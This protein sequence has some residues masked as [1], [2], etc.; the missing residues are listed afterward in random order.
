LNEEQQQAL[1]MPLASRRLRTHVARY[2]SNL[3]SPAVISIPLVI[4]VALYHTHN[5]FTALAYAAATLFFLSAGPMLYIAVGVRLGKFTDI[6]V[7][8]RSQR[9]G[10]FLFS[11]LS[12]LVGLFMLTILH[13]P[14][15]LQTVMLTV[16]LT[17]CAYMLITFWWK[18][19][20]HASILAGAVTML[21]ALYGNMML[22]GYVLVVLVCWSR[23]VLRRHTT[24]QVIAGAL[25]STLITI[26]AIAIRGV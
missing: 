8:V 26:A 12:T 22:A 4:L 19:S 18:I 14:R 24:A 17:G 15:D 9:T 3:F 16:V 7:S 2:I 5:T 25:V 13:G 23:V 6:D 1:Q 21:L 11:I 20:L 10:P